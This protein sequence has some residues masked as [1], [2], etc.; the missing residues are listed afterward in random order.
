MA[1]PMNSCYMMPP[2]MRMPVG[3]MASGFPQPSP[4]GLTSL[5]SGIPGMA[6]A[7]MAGQQNL[8]PHSL[9]SISSAA[10]SQMGYQP[11]REG[12]QAGT[13]R[14]GSAHS[15]KEGKGGGPSGVDLSGP[16]LQQQQ[17]QQQQQYPLQSGAPLSGELPGYPLGSQLG[18][19]L[20][21]TNPPTS[22]Q[23]MQL[24]QQFLQMGGGSGQA[25]LN[26]VNHLQQQL[27]QQ[28]QQQQW[29][30]QIPTLHVNP[31]V[32]LEPADTSNPH[33]THDLSHGLGA[34][35]M[36]QQLGNSLQNWQLQQN[37]LTMGSGDQ[38]QQ[39][40]QQQM[41]LLQ[42]HQQQMQLQWLQESRQG[43][44]SQGGEDSKQG[45]QQQLSQQL[46][47]QQHLQPQPTQQQQQQPM[48]QQMTP[49]SL[50]QLQV[51]QGTHS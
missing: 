33:Q 25:D 1:M 32:K 19:S 3:S 7:P 22:Q 10:P 47:P 29:Q 20:N 46:M 6:S 13:P 12:A 39:Q 28:L 43:L 42:F 48:P 11:A 45:L 34:A 2:G 16:H 30:Q 26:S 38:M 37:G 36:P 23:Q 9:P 4:V 49:A 50:A 31:G 51:R 44:P 21:V 17:Q 14:S 5:P 24:Q 27:P 40:Q 18:M 35:Q 8:Q 41:S 15:S